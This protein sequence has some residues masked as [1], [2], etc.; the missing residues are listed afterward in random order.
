MTLTKYSGYRPRHWLQKKRLIEAHFQITR[1]NKK[2]SS[3]YLELGFESFSH[4]SYVFKKQFGY[5]PKDIRSLN[6]GG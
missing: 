2:P 6:I 1:E 3:I 4:F 5:S